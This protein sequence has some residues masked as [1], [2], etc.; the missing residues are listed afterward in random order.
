MTGF[1]HVER[2]N[3]ATRIT[4]DRGHEGNI[5]SDAMAIELTAIIDKAG[6]ESRYIV[7]RTTGRNFCLGRETPRP[8]PGATPAPVEAVRVRER[9]D[10]VFNFYNSFRRSRA[11]VITAVQGRAI[12]F[13]CAM[14]SLCDVTIASEEAT[15]AIPEML[16]NIM[17]TI[18]MSACV[19]RATRKGLLYMV[20]SCQEI[21]ARTALSFG[22][23]SQ[24]V[25]AAK[26]DSTLEEL[27]ASLDKR[28]LNALLSPKDFTNHAMGMNVQAATDFARNLHATINSSAEMTPIPEDFE[29]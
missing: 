14:A 15:F 28:K 16:R 1:I 26:L 10:A 24:V 27:C 17:P 18:A 2:R 9:S 8:K 23:V 29:F 20:Y 6:A 5:V 7:L 3:D 12:G 21:D 11:P 25:P 19:D 22:L 13:G 4:L